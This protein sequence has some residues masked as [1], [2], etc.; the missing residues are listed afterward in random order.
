MKS[1][2]FL[3]T[4][5][6]IFQI[7]GW[8]ILTVGISLSFYMIM[9]ISGNTYPDDAHYVMVQDYKD[10]FYF[11]F[12]SI[13]VFLLIMALAQFINLS[14]NIAEDIHSIAENVYISTQRHISKSQ[15][16]ENI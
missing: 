11:L 7:T 12:G 8:V 16:S 15:H 6:V 14:L 13:I 10:T 2:K 4:I 3:R 1:Y 5:S 9:K